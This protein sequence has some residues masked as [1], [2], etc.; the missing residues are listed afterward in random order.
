MVELIVWEKTH[1]Q[2]DYNKLI[3]SL[4]WAYGELVKERDKYK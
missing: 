4:E 1:L 3:K 2:T